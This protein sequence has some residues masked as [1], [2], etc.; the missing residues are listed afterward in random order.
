MCRSS[1]AP[2]AIGKTLKQVPPDF[3]SWL[4]T[5]DW[6][7]NYGAK[8]APHA[9]GVATSNHTHSLKS[10][11][12]PRRRKVTGRYSPTKRRSRLRKGGELTGDA[13]EASE[14]LGGDLHM[15]LEGERVRDQTQANV[16]D[17]KED[18]DLISLNEP[19]EGGN[20]NGGD[21]DTLLGV[22]NDDKDTREEVTASLSRRGSKEKLSRSSSDSEDDSDEDDNEQGVDAQVSVLTDD[23][24]TMGGRSA[25]AL[26]AIKAVVDDATESPNMAVLST[27]PVAPPSSRQMGSG[28]F[29]SDSDSKSGHSVSSR[30]KHKKKSGAARSKK[31]SSSSGGGRAG[32]SVKASAHV[33]KA[34]Q[35]PQSSS[36]SILTPHME[37]PG[38]IGVSLL[39]SNKKQQS[40]THL[41]TTDDDDSHDSDSATS[42][43]K[44]RTPMTLKQRK[45]RRKES[46]TARL[47][48]AGIEGIRK[49]SGS[50]HGTQSTVVEGTLPEIC[51][52]K[53]KVTRTSSQGLGV[54]LTRRVE[55]VPG[56][57]GEGKMPSVKK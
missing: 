52:R 35:R 3:K 30:K 42:Q 31:P 1:T 54:K 53:V 49:S 38:S 55:N 44:H 7:M 13:S 41:T 8:A 25:S 22:L 21:E 46:L 47:K 50:T 9:D 57:S 33:L 28:Y 36:G 24:Q 19:P 27:A 56:S 45:E 10:S 37:R 11:T 5:D 40:N 6:Y 43:R 4:F 29:S 51:N 2:S 23:N 48:A 26:Q 17:T 39:D 32:E 15:L 14:A 34:S 16:V 20:G 18:D 12:G